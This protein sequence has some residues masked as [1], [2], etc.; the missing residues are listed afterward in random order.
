MEILEEIRDIIEKSLSSDDLYI[1]D[2][3]MT[4]T[5]R[6]KL[7]ITLDGENEGISID[8]CGRI[9][10]IVGELIEES[11]LIED[12]YQLEVSSPGIDQPLKLPKQYKKNINR[13]LEI[14]TEDKK[15]TGKLEDVNESGIVIR[16]IKMRGK[17]KDYAKET[18]ALEFDKIDKANIL[19]SFN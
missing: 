12:A 3:I 7:S 13:D 8:E 16:P 11:N 5:A 10:K 4:G 17:L 6:K 9:S 14:I 19:I 18:L 1:V 2:I 15:F